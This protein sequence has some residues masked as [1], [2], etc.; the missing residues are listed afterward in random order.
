M[1]INGKF[2]TSLITSLQP[3]TEL[4]LSIAFSSFDPTAAVCTQPNPG[5]KM[6]KTPLKTDLE[7]LARLESTNPLV[8][9]PPKKARNPQI[10]HA[11]KRNHGLSAAEKKVA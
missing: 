5:K 3:T 7:L 9:L 8:P 6:A 4:R 11:P 10:A 2:V 1:S